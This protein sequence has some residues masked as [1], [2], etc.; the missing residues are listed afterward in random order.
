MLTLQGSECCW[1]K[2]NAN[3]IIKLL[4]AITVVHYTELLYQS[5]DI[6]E[7]FL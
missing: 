3:H 1:V 4:V 2:R 7:F 6:V 5:S